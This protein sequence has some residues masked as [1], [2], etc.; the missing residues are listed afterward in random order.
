MARFLITL[1][2]S[3]KQNCDWHIFTVSI[4]FV[5]KSLHSL[6]TTQVVVHFRKI[7]EQSLD[8]NLHFE[9]TRTETHNWNWKIFICFLSEKMTEILSDYCALLMLP[10]WKK[11][12]NFFR[13]KNWIWSTHHSCYAL[14]G[15]HATG[16]AI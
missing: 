4:L 6:L 10:R 13:L 5:R 9:W 16:F 12:M 7:K 14:H 11:Y 3:S 15:C 2:G 1:L 8:H